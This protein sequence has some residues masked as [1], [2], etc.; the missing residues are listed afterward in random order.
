MICAP[1][2]VCKLES[3][4]CNTL[5]R[6][7][8]VFFYDFI[9]KNQF[10]P[11]FYT[12]NDHFS[13]FEGMLTLWRHSEVI[14]KSLVLILVSMERGCPYPYTGSTFR[15][16]WPSVF[17]IWRGLQQPPFGKYVWEKPSGEQEL[18]KACRIIIKLN[19]AQENFQASKTEE[20][21]VLFFLYIHWIY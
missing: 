1:N 15:A 8:H 17:I 2:F 10:L 3:S 16:I 14:H 18:N 12:Q 7:S 4:F 20:L 5:S 21:S 6:K 19:T 13:I 11:L 9:R